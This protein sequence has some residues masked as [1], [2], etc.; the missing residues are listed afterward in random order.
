MYQPEQEA[1]KMAQN[2]LKIWCDGFM[3]FYRKTSFLT[4]IVICA[5]ISFIF[6]FIMLNKSITPQREEIKKLKSTADS[7][8]VDDDINAEINEL[9]NKQKKIFLAVESLK[10]TNTALVEFYGTLSK[11]E[12]GKNILE[13]RKF[14]E[15]NSLRILNEDRLQQGQSANNYAPLQTA[16]THINIKLPSSFNFESYRFELL[17]TYTDLR[18][19]MVDVYL[20]N[21]LFFVNN[22]K[23][24]ESKEFI[25]DKELRQH[26]ALKCSFE[27]H[28]PYLN[29]K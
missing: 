18:N 13:L 8:K 20:A 22:I 9:K 11:A 24:S 10:Q 5:V 29:N 23:I 6:A 16:P 17:G 21:S 27:V 15:K 3:R 26:P 12:T 14:M 2:Q 7:I 28:V 1:N 4:R 25:T 19:F